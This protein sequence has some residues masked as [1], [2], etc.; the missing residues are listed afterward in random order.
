MTSLWCNIVS[1]I[2]IKQT[3]K[4]KGPIFIYTLC[5]EHKKPQKQ[6]LKERFKFNFKTRNKTRLCDSKIRTQDVQTNVKTNIYYVNI[7]KHEHKKNM[8]MLRSQVPCRPT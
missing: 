8:I 6:R 3:K 4:M 2:G 7:C 5:H 1:K